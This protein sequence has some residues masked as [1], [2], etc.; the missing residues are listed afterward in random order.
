MLNM[1]HAQPPRD[2]YSGAEIR[3]A[4]PAQSEHHA[5]SCIFSK[6][7]LKRACFLLPQAFMNESRSLEGEKANAA[8]E[9]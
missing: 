1:L 7:R 3:A 5:T 6:W 8:T 4:W 2:A 9:I